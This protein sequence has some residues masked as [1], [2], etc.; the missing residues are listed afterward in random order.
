[1]KFVCLWVRVLNPTRKQAQNLWLISIK[2][3]K[4]WIYQLIVII[5]LPSLHFQCKG[6]YCS[7]PRN[8]HAQLLFVMPSVWAW[9][10]ASNSG[11]ALPRDEEIPITC[12]GS[13][14]VDSTDPPNNIHCLFSYSFVQ[15]Y[16][17]ILNVKILYIDLSNSVAGFIPVDCFIRLIIHF[18]SEWSD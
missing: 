17:Q 6:I 3:A 7:H 13:K 9:K 4:Q 11:N 1:M 8:V 12:L 16:R 18:F 15:I 2:E 14:D 5:N 10:R